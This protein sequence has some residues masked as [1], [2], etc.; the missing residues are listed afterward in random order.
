MKKKKGSNIKYEAKKNVYD[1]FGGGT[2][3]KK[4]RRKMKRE[5]LQKMLKGGGSDIVSTKMKAPMQGNVM[6]RRK[7]EQYGQCPIH[8][9]TDQRHERSE[10][11]QEVEAMIVDS[12]KS[13]KKKN[14]RKKS[15]K[16]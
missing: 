15:T 7:V 16:R 1:E 11:I 3:K 9:K 10:Q 2:K 6:K 4:R 12:A 13:K 5:K 14:K 8:Q